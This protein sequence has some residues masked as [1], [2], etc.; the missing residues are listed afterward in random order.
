MSLD[1]DAH[2]KWKALTA[3][4]R[5]AWYKSAISF[6]GFKEPT[7]TQMGAGVYYHF[8][9]YTK[10]GLKSEQAEAPRLMQWSTFPP[11][12]S[13]PPWLIWKRLQWKLDP[14]AHDWDKGYK[15]II[16][17]SR[18]RGAEGRS[19]AGRYTQSCTMNAWPGS[20]PSLTF[21]NTRR[22]ALLLRRWPAEEHLAYI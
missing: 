18:L 21:S 15:S 19:T 3:S 22:G 9:L 12:S 14:Q 6:C 5:Q 4:E 13:H 17:S 2:P 7:A 11:V 20:C 8:L 16:C 10:N 1:L